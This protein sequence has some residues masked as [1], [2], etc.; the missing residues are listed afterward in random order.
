MDLLSHVL[1]NDPQV[2]DELLAKNA[3]TGLPLATSSGIESFMVEQAMQTAESFAPTDGAVWR[4]Y[5]SEVTGRTFTANSFL[6]KILPMCG[7][8]DR[9]CSFGSLRL[10]DMGKLVPSICAIT[11]AIQGD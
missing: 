1:K 5:D 11:N 6:E 10:C 3:S 2:R 8:D 7:L 9:E 4:C